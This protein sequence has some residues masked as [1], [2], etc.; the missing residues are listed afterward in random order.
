MLFITH[1]MGVVEYLADRMAVMH[2]GRVVESGPVAQVLSSP[3][4]D[5]TRHLLAAVP[6]LDAIV[7]RGAQTA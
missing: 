5:Y 2:A 7:P 1:N 6:R 3:Q 4:D